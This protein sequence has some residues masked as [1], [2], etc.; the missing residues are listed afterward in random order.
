MLAAVGV[1]LLSTVWSIAGAN[2]ATTSPLSIQVELNVTTIAT[3]HTIH[4]TAVITNASG[5]AIVVQTFNCYQWIFV[6]LANKDVPY[7]PTFLLSGCP[8]SMV[9]LP[10]A[11][12]VPITVSTKYQSCNTRATPRCTKSGMP[13]LPTGRYRVAVI[14]EGGPKMSIRADRQ[15]VTLI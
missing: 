14:T 9:L 3:G 2:A 7:Q 1:S 13:S 12:R 8:G 5:K 11:N 15:R 6:G 10:G 4:G